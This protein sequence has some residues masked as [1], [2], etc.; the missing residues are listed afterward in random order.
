MII[1]EFPFKLVDKIII[2]FHLT[3]LCVKMHVLWYVTE[4]LRN[5]CGQQKVCYLG[6][7]PPGSFSG[8]RCCYFCLFS[9][10]QGHSRIVS[11]ARVCTPPQ[12]TARGGKWSQ[13][14]GQPMPHKHVYNT[15][16][17]YSLA[18]MMSSLLLCWGCSRLDGFFNGRSTRER[19]L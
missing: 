11:A 6:L 18:C 2:F 3:F 16:V 12:Q 14:A 5:I 7:C 19:L 8:W 17:C 10:Y 13:Q 15:C 9:G 1:N 4:L